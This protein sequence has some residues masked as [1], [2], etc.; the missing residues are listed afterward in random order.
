MLADRR[1]DELRGIGAESGGELLAARVR[2]RR[3]LDDG[4]SDRQPRARRRVVF[5][6]VEVDVEL[7]AR[8]SPTIRRLGH[9]RRSPRVHERD[10]SVV[11]PTDRP[12]AIA[13]Q[14][15]GFIELAPR[16]RF[17]GV[18]AGPPHDQLEN[19]DVGRRS[20]NLLEPCFELGKCGIR[21]SPTLP[22]SRTMP[23]KATGSAGGLLADV[24]GSP[25][26]SARSPPAEPVAFIHASRNWRQ[27]AANVDG[28]RVPRGR[29]GNQFT[30]WSRSAALRR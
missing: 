20:A 24:K 17:A 30:G 27:D 3:D 16:Q 1:V 11:I 5:A 26:F 8:E 12:P 15:L 6:Q 28:V 25:I 19:A 7:V 10:L 18:D 22:W 13:D 2:R 14:S 29:L 23:M 21:S 9:K 4:G